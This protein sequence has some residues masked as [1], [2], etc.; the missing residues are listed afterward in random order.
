MV[1]DLN[2]DMALEHS[3]YFNQPIFKHS[4]NEIAASGM[5][6]HDNSKMRYTV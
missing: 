5:R 2:V 3:N 1:P 4:L 6:Q